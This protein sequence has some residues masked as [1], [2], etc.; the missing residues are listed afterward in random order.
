MT[1]EE[2]RVWEDYVINYNHSNPTDQISYEVTFVNNDIYEVKL[3]DLKVD[4]EGEQ[5]YHRY[6]FQVCPKVQPSTNLPE[7]KDIRLYRASYWSSAK[8]T[9][10]SFK[11]FAGVRATVKTSLE[12]LGRL[13]EVVDDMG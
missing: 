1:K 4:R 6:L 7:P 12:R 13:E 3:L 8:K 5:Q 10:L 11:S 9:R 2:Y